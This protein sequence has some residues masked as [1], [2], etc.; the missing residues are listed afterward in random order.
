MFNVHGSI[1][2]QKCYGRE[3]QIVRNFT[4]KQQRSNPL[5]IHF[6]YETV[7]GVPY[8]KTVKIII[9]QDMAKI[10]I[11]RGFEG[12]STSIQKQTM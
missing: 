8:N 12:F 3:V 6:E 11:L 10:H 7:E 1:L 2:G 5:V 4:L 9:L